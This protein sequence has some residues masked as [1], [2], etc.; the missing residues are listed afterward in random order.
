M[1]RA[2][3]AWF[4]AAAIL[5]LIVSFSAPAFPV[6]DPTPPQPAQAVRGY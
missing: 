4:V 5:T 1:I 2:R 6:E 3:A